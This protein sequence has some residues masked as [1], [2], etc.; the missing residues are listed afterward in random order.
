LIFSRPL[1]AASVNGVASLLTA[2]E[3]AIA[4]VH[5]AMLHA[6]ENPRPAPQLSR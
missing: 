6:D 4:I 3:N 2:S 5:H 1:V